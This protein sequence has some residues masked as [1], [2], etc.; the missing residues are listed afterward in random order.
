[1]SSASTSLA[2]GV[3]SPANFQGCRF[4]SCFL[5]GITD[6]IQFSKHRECAWID[7]LDLCYL[8]VK[9]LPTLKKILYPLLSP[10]P[11]NEASAIAFK[12]SSDK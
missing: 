7:S 3:S 2:D 11:G 9:L 8:L 4:T 6:L 1:M 10:W 12:V 5:N